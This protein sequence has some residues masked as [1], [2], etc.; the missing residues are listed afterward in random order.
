M[1]K[2]I[3]KVRVIDT[4]HLSAAENMALDAA[5]LEAR[6]KNLVPDTIRFLSFKP[7]C[8]LVGSFQSTDRE[9]RLDYCRQNSIEINRR[10]TGGGALY[11]SGN[12]IGWEYFS[13]G[14]SFGGCAGYEQYYELFC[15][16][17]ACGI[18]RFGLNSAFRPRNDIE[19]N[20]RKI[21]GSGGTSLKN[22]FMFQG[23]LLVDLDIDI[24]LRAL[25]VPVEKLKYSEINSLKDRLTWLSRELGYCPGRGDIINNLTQGFAQYFEIET[26]KGKLSEEEIKI[27]NEKLPYF[28]S[29]SH[30]YKITEEKSSG[31]VYSFHKS[32]KKVIKCTA[33]V[34]LKRKILKNVYFTGDFFCYPARA[35]Y[36]LE[37]SLKNIRIDINKDLPASAGNEGI[38]KVLS[39]NIQDRVDSFFDNY[40]KI[41]GI[42]KNIIK[43]LL[44]GAI[45]RL[46]ICR[47]GV[48]NE[49]INDI[50]TVCTEFGNKN[51]IDI[52]LIPYCA[53]HPECAYRYRQG[54]DFCGKC[55]V[56]DA[57]KLAKAYKIRHITITSFEHLMETL[58]KLKKQNKKYFAGCCCEAFYLK[59]LNHF[60][61]KG[62]AGILM[63]IDNTTCYD[64]GKEMDAYAGRFEGFTDLKLPLLEKIFKIHNKSA[65]SP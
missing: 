59:H 30:I 48:E 12:D 28:K 18:N 24:M 23:T 37:S 32:E 14:Q 38:E 65:V 1:K 46:D 15:S 17:A 62:L 22:A 51:I 9:L 8:A 26:Y 20:G 50:Y 53:K 6:D 64:L 33:N 4:G 60:E 63:N 55:T 34:D 58:E 5:I 25:R 29:S 41:T 43:N 36:D 19:I 52:F 35:V 16:A 42:S 49:N 2:E 56:G 61:E 45:S 47:H 40:G 21:S 54:C 44:N 7:H 13:T 31:F 39:K 27:F 11:W 3:K 10:I 57:I